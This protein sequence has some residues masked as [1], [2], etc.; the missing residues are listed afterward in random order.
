VRNKNMSVS[1]FEPIKRIENL[2]INESMILVEDKKGHILVQRTIMG[3][4]F[5]TV[6]YSKDFCKEHDVQI[7]YV[8]A[9]ILL[10]K[11]TPIVWYNT[12]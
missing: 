4:M 1:E 11:P 8:N 5:A 9:D 3:Y 2:K 6:T 12:T 10:R 7:K